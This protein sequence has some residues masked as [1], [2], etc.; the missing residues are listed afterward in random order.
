MLRHNQERQ[1]VCDDIASKSVHFAKSLNVMEHK[2]MFSLVHLIASPRAAAGGGKLARKRQWNI[3]LPAEYTCRTT[4][5]RS[6][7]VWICGHM[8]KNR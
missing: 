5:T 4:Q 7:T 8:G 1:L 3:A 6:R 2:A